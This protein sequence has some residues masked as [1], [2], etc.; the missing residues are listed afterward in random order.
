[1]GD[2][3]RFQAFENDKGEIIN[4]EIILS[5]IENKA[6]PVIKKIVKRTL[7]GEVPNLELQ[8]T[9]TLC[10]YLYRLNSRNPQNYVQMKIDSPIFDNSMREVYKHHG[11]EFE[12]GKKEIEGHRKL[13]KNLVASGQVDFQVKDMQ[14]FVANYDVD[15]IRISSDEKDKEFVL[16]SSYPTLYSTNGNVTGIFIMVVHPRISLVFKC[17]DGY[18]TMN[19]F[20]STGVDL[21]NQIIF[22]ASDYLV[23]KNKETLKPFTPT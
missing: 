21:V 5:K 3:N 4:P 13:A 19:T 7:A 22:N 10:E 6:A 12:S 15:Y 16:G 1:M 14:D 11:L 20:V 2:K 17:R 23:A 9:E 8:Q 18:S